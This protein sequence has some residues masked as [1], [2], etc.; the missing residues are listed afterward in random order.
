MKQFVKIENALEQSKQELALKP[1]FNLCDHFRIF[2]QNQNAYITTSDLER[3]LRFFN[4]YPSREELYLFYRNLDNDNDGRLKF[5]DL[6]EAFLP[7]LEE[8]NVIMANR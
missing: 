6:S 7:K 2:D 3:G 4:V 1:D 5:M 8:Y